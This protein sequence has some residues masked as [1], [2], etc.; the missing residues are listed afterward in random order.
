[1]VVACA[2]SALGHSVALAALAWLRVSAVPWL[3][4][5][6]AGQPVTV[7][8]V[9]G[10]A[11]DDPAVIRELAAIEFLADA[12]STT[13]AELVPDV[14]ILKETSTASPVN[15]TA[16][17]SV[18]TAPT[19]VA[20]RER[21]R[22]RRADDSQPVPE[23]TATPSVPRRSRRPPPELVS[24]LQ[25]PELVTQAVPADDPGARVSETARLP[26]L[27]PAPDYPLEA[28]R[29]L[30]QGRVLLL[31][32]LDA[33]GKVVQVRLRRS[34]GWPSLDEAAMAAVQQWR[35]MPAVAGSRPAAS[36][37]LVPIRFTLRQ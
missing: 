37:V 13:T 12:A 14:E 17:S 29:A 16:T 5:V 19:P 36:H 24:P 27:N 30:Q 3:S 26:I 18:T 32:Q 21:E 15:V 9:A 8:V 11:R 7:T 28:R 10:V 2:A 20:D 25:V 4:A 33:A 31:V 22:Q 1:M 23:P 35:F 6:D 34:C